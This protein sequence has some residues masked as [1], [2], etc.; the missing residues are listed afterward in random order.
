VYQQARRL[1]DSPERRALYRNMAQLVH[2]YTPWVLLTHPVSADLRQSWLK[3]Y[4]RH[5]V[6]F[7]AWRYLDVDPA[8]RADRD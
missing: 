8:A 3:N 2:A 6:E 4:K 5:P 1:T 7:T